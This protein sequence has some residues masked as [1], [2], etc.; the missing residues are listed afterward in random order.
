LA[1]H[2]V[3]LGDLL[4]H[5]KAVML[6]FVSPNCAPCKA[7]LPFLLSWQRDYG[8]QLTIAVISRGEPEEVQAKLNKYEVKHLLLQGEAKTNDDYQA[9]WTPAA[10][11]I[12]P[13][14]RI[15][16][17]L[18]TG[19]EAI[20][21]LVTYAVATSETATP[22]KLGNSLFNVGEAAPR[23]TLPDLQGEEVAFASLL[24]RNTL[25]LFW[26][27]GCGFCQAMAEELK[28]WEAKPTLPDT[29]LVF[30]ST[31]ERDDIQASSTGFRA[32]F[33]HDKDNDIAPLFGANGTPSGLML[34]A[35][36]RIASSLAVGERHLLAL[37]GVRKVE[38][39]LAKSA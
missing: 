29:Q 9:P 11:L 16:N 18:A 7:L 37:L 13:Q 25:L 17:A 32:T 5:G 8:E 6:L 19:D 22:I 15:A 26:N 30:V 34:D 38:L 31:G 12:N 27:P 2:Q 36:G 21:A 20:R 10:I 23:F 33:L 39:P 28:R 35:Q 24:K 1:G 14:G 4:A 3:S